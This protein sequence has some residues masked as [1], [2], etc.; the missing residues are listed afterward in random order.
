MVLRLGQRSGG[1][2]DFAIVRVRDQAPE[3]FFLVDDLAFDSAE[4][5]S[6]V[7]G[8]SI[9]SLLPFHL[10]NQL[11]ERSATLLAYSTGLLQSALG[12]E[13]EIGT[14]ISDSGVYAFDFIPHAGFPSLSH[15]KGRVEIEGLFVGRQLSLTLAKGKYAYFYCLGQK[16]SLRHKTNCTQPYVS[17]L[18]AEK[19]VEDLFKKIQL[20]EEWV[21]RLTEELEEEIVDRQATASEL[22]VALTRRLA[23]LAEEREKLLRAYYAN[24]IPLGLL[25]RD[26]DRITAQEEKAKAEL[27]ATEADLDKW[28]EVLTLAIKLAGSCHPAYLKASPKVRRRFN[29]AVLKAVYIRDGKVARA[30]FTD[31]FAALFSRP[32]SNKWVKVPPVGTERKGRQVSY[33]RLSAIYLIERM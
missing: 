32:S 4:V 16:N 10:L 33:L 1:K 18:D 25:K 22:R 24:A 31:V 21:T 13:D 15:N 9:R 3:C 30:E 2:T 14:P 12:L 19:S 17:T 8:G 28:Q 20:P 7:P 6:F 29:E 23:A 26:Q 5:R 11:T 27:A